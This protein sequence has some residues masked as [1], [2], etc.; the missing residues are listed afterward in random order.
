MPGHHFLS[1]SRFDAEDF[2]LRLHNALEAGA[3]SFPIW[4]DKID[5]KPGQDWDEQIAEAIRVC[6]SLLFVMTHDS[7]NPQSTC[8]LEWT[9]ALK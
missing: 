9:R 1:Y 3:P 7:V 4:L 5:L 6:D 8:K 2:A